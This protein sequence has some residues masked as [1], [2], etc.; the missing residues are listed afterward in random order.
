MKRAFTGLQA[1]IIYSS[2][3]A[4]GQEKAEEKMIDEG[5]WLKKLKDYGFT[6][7]DFNSDKEKAIKRFGKNARDS[8]IIWGLFQKAILKNSSDYGKLWGAYLCMAS[9]LES[10]N[11]P[12][13]QIL[14]IQELEYKFM[15]EGYKQKGIDKLR[16]VAT[17]GG[18]R[19]CKE[20]EK[21]NGKVLN[22][23]EALKKMSIPRKCKN[24]LCRCVYA[25]I[26]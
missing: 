19:L 11:K 4:Q 17:I 12:K 6:E 13:Q 22:I 7:K 18:Q 26:Q 24:K 1:Y 8:D 21:L 3:G 14:Q 2:L 20:C 5:F 9:F 25:P 10:E 16:C 23:D 15:L